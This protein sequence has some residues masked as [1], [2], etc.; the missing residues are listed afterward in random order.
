MEKENKMYSFEIVDKAISTTAIGFSCG[1]ESFK[2]K[3]KE[4]PEEIQSVIIASV[5]AGYLVFHAQVKAGT[6]KLSEIEKKGLTK[7][8]IDM[9]V[10]DIINKLFKGKQQS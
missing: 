10:N 5:L 1:P 6:S 8:D 2:E 3:L 4:L 9:F 7:E